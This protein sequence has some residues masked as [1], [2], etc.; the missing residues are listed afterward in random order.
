[1]K[2]LYGDRSSSCAV[3]IRTCCGWDEGRQQSPSPSCP[4]LQGGSH[5][6][7]VQTSQQKSQLAESTGALLR[8]AVLIIIN[9]DHVARAVLSS[10]AWCSVGVGSVWLKSHLIE[11]IS[12]KHP[13]KSV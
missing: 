6:A 5:R 1:V 10:M 3:P 9:N 13:P 11:Q 7:G 2:E 8:S 4:V 12:A